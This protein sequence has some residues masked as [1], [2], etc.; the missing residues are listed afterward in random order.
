VPLLDAALAFALT[1]LVVAAVVQQIVALLQ[2]A[3]K[4]RGRIMREMLED[5][6]GDAFS[7]VAERELN[8]IKT[9]GAAQVSDELYKAADACGISDV[10][11]RDEL[12]TLVDISTEDLKRR[13]EQ[14][15][16]GKKLLTELRDQA[17]KVFDE[18]GR[19]YEIVGKKFTA[20]F[21]TS[22]MWWA[23]VVALFLALVINI[24]SIHIANSYIRNESLREGVVIRMNAITS[25]LDGRVEALEPTQG[26]VTKEA[27]KGAIDDTRTQI[28]YLTGLGFPIGWSYFPH[29]YIR[30]KSSTDYKNRSTPYGLALWVIGIVL[31]AYLATLGAPFWHDTI[32][33]IDVY[34]DRSRGAEKSGK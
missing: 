12:T 22:S 26:K 11:K 21:R 20:K 31:T 6:F 5:Y 13:L 27:L 29:V 7:Q 28:D 4:V 33:G 3:R 24:D 15:D 17:D 32:R 1:M 18:L 2:K 25:E 30:D 16:M 9:R 8:R 19:H 14:S 23:F 34:R 10:V